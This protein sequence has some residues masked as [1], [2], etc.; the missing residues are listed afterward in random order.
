[1]SIG[2]FLVKNL[3]IIPIIFISLRY[4]FDSSIVY[5][6]LGEILAGLGV[7][8]LRIAIHSLERRSNFGAAWQ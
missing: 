5:L 2:E 3:C 1:M 4:R 8:Q 7:T 6:R